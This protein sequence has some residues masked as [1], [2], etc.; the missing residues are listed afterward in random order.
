MK[1]GILCLV[2]LKIFP[3]IWYI[4][5]I[6]LP[7]IFF[8]QH[9]TDSSQP[10]PGN[11]GPQLKKYGIEAAGETTDISQ[12]WSYRC[13]DVNDTDNKASAGITLGMGSANERRRYLVTPSL[14]GWAHTQNDT[15]SVAAE[16]TKIIWSNIDA[17][18]ET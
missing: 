1:S 13:P 15:S 6:R 7:L 18:T 2:P 9:T 11:H 12:P 10:H 16:L 3:Q 5:Y 17:V 8:T 14:I 4:A